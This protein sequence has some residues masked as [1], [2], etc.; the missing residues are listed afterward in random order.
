MERTR[1]GARE[2]WD[3][4]RWAALVAAVG[5]VLMSWPFGAGGGRGS[6]ETAAAP[7]ARDLAREMEAALSVMDGVGQVR[8]LLTEESD[9]ER[10]LAQDVSLSSR[11][12]GDRSR[13][14]ETVLTDL[15]SGEGPVVTRT[16]YPT[17]RGA[18]VVCEGGGNASVRLAVTR[19]VTALTGLSADRVAVER[20][21]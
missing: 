1:G 5:I 10:L 12:D 18:L 19:A 21:Q 16:V 3:K 11:G 7:A 14:A 6:A 20:W 17:W 4:Y 15:G 9:G 13:S 2:L 8:V